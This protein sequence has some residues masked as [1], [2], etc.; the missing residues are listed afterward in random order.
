[1][2]KYLGSK[3][4][5]VPRIVEIVAA[6]DAA[7]PV[8]SVLDLFAGTSRV[9]HALKRAGYRVLANDDATYAHTLAT[10]YVQADA[11]D[12][13][14]AIAALLDDL[15]KTPP[16]AGYVTRT[17][18]EEARY[19]TP[20]NG[21]R[22]DGIRAAI[23]AR[24]LAPELAALALT[25]LLEA[26]DRV[27]STTGVQMAYLKRWAPRAA[28]PLTL[29]APDLLPRARNG[30][31]AA[32]RLDALDAARALTADVAYLDPPYNQHAYLG[33]YHVWETIA[34]G[35]APEAYGI[36]RKRI[37]TRER[38]SRFNSRRQHAAALREVIAAVDARVLVVSFSDE[39]FV[40][41]DEVVA[42]LAARGG[43]VRVFEHDFKRYVGA[44][45]G[46]HNRKGE[47]VGR[48]S[49]LRNREFLFVAGDPAALARLKVSPEVAAAAV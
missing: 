42:M 46:I 39:G 20:E 17:F 5:L 27:D 47:K 12:H 23:A 9:G 28:H 19:F 33:N 2:I 43:D 3:R 38:T 7:Q 4:L 31:G 26:A 49:H 44:Q 34:R 21:A 14:A 32:H 22:I 25:A 30:K 8:T 15:S 45:I 24:G 36:A 10:A 29:R 41:R 1:M 37:D 16:A 18:C 40:S 48:V 6:L 13:A 35:D 11:E